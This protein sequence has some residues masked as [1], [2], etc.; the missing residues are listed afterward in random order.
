MGVPVASA[1][2]VPQAAPAAPVAEPVAPTT[3]APDGVAPAA[4]AAA[5]PRASATASSPVPA[6]APATDPVL[7]Q[8]TLIVAQMTGYPAD[9]LDPDLDLEADLGVDTVK[10]AEVFAAVRGHYGLERDANLKLRDFPTL[11][12]VAGWVRQRGGLGMATVPTVDMA[13]PTG[14]AIAPA[15]TPGPTA[16]P[17]VSPSPASDD[18]MAQVTAIVAQMTGYPADLLDPDLDLEADLGVDTVK[19]AEVFAAVRGHYQLERDP[20][21]KLRDFPTLRHV[22]GW[23]RERGGM[24]AAP[25]AAAVAAPV[26][27]VAA[28]PATALAAAPAAIPTAAPVPA[29]D[30]VMARVTAIVAEMTGYPAD[31][32]EPDLDLEADLGVDT[33]KQAEVFAAVRGHYQLERDPNLK[34]RDFPTLRHVAGWVR[35]RGGMGAAPA[36][37]AVAAPVAAVAAPPATALAA[38]PA[39]IPTAAPVPATDDVMARV[40][41][42]VAEMTGYPA[43][44]LEPDLDLEADLGVD[45]VKQAE[46]FA[47]VRGH[48]QLERDPNLK[49]RDFPTLRHVAGWVRQ[50]AGLALPAPGEA[51]AA[52]AS[53]A[54]ASQ[55][56]DLVQGDLRAIDALPRR[57]PMPT[58]RPAAPS[59]LPT[60]V[61]LSG[62]RVVVVADES[63]VA[64]ALGKQLGKAG[65][66]VLGLPAGAPTA[67]LLASLDEWQKQGPIAGVYWLPALDP[68]GALDDLDAAAWHEALRCRVKA[69]YAV[70]RQLYDT[71]PFLVVATRL[72]GCHG[73]DAAG[74][75]NPLGGA[76]VGLAKS[77]RKERPLALVKAVDLAAGAKAATVAEQLIEETLFDPGCVE[78]GRLGERR[79]G[80]AFVEVPFPPLGEDGQVAPGDGLVLGRES[81]FVVTGAAGSIVSAITADLAAASG[82]GIFHLLDL[83][84]APERNDPD[85]AA[86]RADRDGLKATLAARMKAAGER[87]TPVAIERELARIERL[88]AALGAV[89]AIEATGGS[90]HYH[91]LDLR[92]GAAV[93]AAIAD[94]RQRHG[95]IDVLLHAA[96]LEISRNLPEKSPAEFDLV[97]DVKSDGWFNLMRAARDLPIGAT[98]VFSSVAGRFGNQGQTDYAAANDLLCKITSHL[99]RTRPQMRA[100]ALDWTAWGGIGMATRGSIPK[101]MEMAGVQL[102]PPE[103]GVA[104]IRRELLSSAFRGEVIVAGELGLMAAEL[105][106]G[107][108]ADLAAS[109]TGSKPGPM[110]GT[111]SL[112][113]HEGVVVKTTLDPTQQPFLD[114]HRIDG[115]AVLPGVMG[116]E[117]FAEAAA[118]LAPELHVAA[119]EDVGFAA[120]L[121]FYRDEPRTITVTAV[122]SPDGEGLVA[123][124]RLVAERMLAGQSQPQRTVHFTGRV[125]LAAAAPTGQKTAPPGQAEGAV[126]TPQQVY[127]FYFH[128]P[129][130]Q[131]VAS[132]WRAGELSV[133]AMADGL[134][135]NH[136]PA[137]LPLLTAPRPLELCFQAAGLWQAGLEG[138]LA[139]PAHVDS[140]RVLRD[141]AKA[142]GPLHATAR[143]TAPGCFDCLVVDGKGQVIVRLDGYRSVPLP[144]PISDAVAAQL[145]EVFRG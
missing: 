117:A 46:V 49:L 45:T 35:E 44:L 14:A 94:V 53:P 145:R 31:L 79:F 22:A 16:A 110:R 6:P 48:Y 116:I 132:A 93:E 115:I 120:P 10:Q 5:A 114:H 123:H 103:A 89:Q 73:Y 28:P 55:A 68:E 122:L 3:K 144:T 61:G 111:A 71:S 88:S 128:G 4:L 80:V 141:P 140:V 40:T 51:T 69:L 143:Q 18:V 52:K 65:A 108:G 20:N 134:P 113:V 142:K 124:T 13:A 127:A 137:E 72:G 8:V 84:P 1:A 95:R 7:A 136:S 78:I 36:A 50:R 60:G 139:L 47:A 42:I 121:K 119:V 129:A 33:V 23:V 101:I 9:L 19:Q 26:A 85:L 74:A 38:A 109:A 87:P 15:A 118:L 102:L 98:V 76:V 104:W 59:C 125:R 57:V 107:G 43:D 64:K 130:Y 133:A 11:R 63:G 24:G 100:L 34:L 12:H 83:T 82:G 37:A 96:G 32:L 41:A 77:Y 30:D 86:F 66:Q 17:V 56:P 138:R 90:A 91:A 21:L 126:M 92:D 67:E 29:A 106:A 112:S 70:M 81:V 39:A 62:S 2:V 58:L 99:R 27:A 135:P 131:V 97:F 54:I 75:I 105:H 25:A